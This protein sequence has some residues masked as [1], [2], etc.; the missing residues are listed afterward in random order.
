MAE[1]SFNPDEVEDTGSDLLPAGQYI[2]QII[3]SELAPTKNGKGQ[4]LNLTFEIVDGPHAKRRIWEGLNIF[5]ENAQAQSISQRD[6]KRICVAV[7]HTGVL[8]NSEDLHFKPFRARVAVQTDK[9]GNFDPRNAIKGY[10]PLSKGGDGHAPAERPQAA[11]TTSKP[12]Q[13]S[14]RPATNASRPWGKK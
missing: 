6:L 10:E 3:E 11:S 5:H 8:S 13:E 4:R 9:T 14:S 12:T 2:V 7:G 1:F